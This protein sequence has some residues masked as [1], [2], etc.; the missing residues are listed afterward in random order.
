MRDQSHQG[1][2][3]G[4]SALRFSLAAGL[5]AMTAGCGEGGIDDV[6]RRHDSAPAAING[7][8][9]IN[10]LDAVAGNP[11]IAGNASGR[12]AVA[13][14]RRSQS[15]PEEDAGHYLRLY[16]AEGEPIGPEFRVAPQIFRDP[17]AIRVTMDAQ[18]NTVLAWLEREDPQGFRVRAQR[19]S[20]NGA[21][22]GAP[23]AVGEVGVALPLLLIHV[24]SGVSVAMRDN[25]DFVVAW[26]RHVMREVRSPDLLA[27]Q[28]HTTSIYA[29]SFAADGSPLSD[30]VQVHSTLPSI[31]LTSGRSNA[32]PAVAI[33]ASGHYVVSWTLR[34]QGRSSVHMRAFSLTGE[35][36]G[37]QQRVSPLLDAY[38]RQP[39]IAMT[40]TGDF[41]IAWTGPSRGENSSGIYARKYAAGGTALS[42]AVATENVVPA[43]PAQ[44]APSVTTAQDGSFVVS[45]LGQ[46]PAAGGGTRRD[47]VLQ[48]F[49]AAG[50]LACPPRVVP[51][52][53]GAPRERP[54]IANLGGQRFGIAWREG[55]TTFATD[56]QFKALDLP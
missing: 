13:W 19:V 37:S 39:A 32:T 41:A 8:T 2:A 25:G 34:E 3:R 22:I 5:L 23:I 30:E 15:L 56:I 12:F 29:R 54:A 1:A 16:A 40:P 53:D 42:Q 33:D 31:T 45:W 50:Q 52:P 47:V 21:L 43:I 4:V 20:A 36:N 18:G 14:T 44:M 35:A 28:T 9:Q 51:E 7:Q 48:C 26:S 55:H 11:V 38:A 17:T 24:G 27:V 10:A 6:E 46:S 49:D